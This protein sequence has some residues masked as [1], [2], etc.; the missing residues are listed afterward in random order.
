MESVIVIT[1]IA[2]AF[3]IYS[4]IDVKIKVTKGKGSWLKP[5]TWVKI[6]ISKE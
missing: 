1:T 6:K 3:I 2:I 5:L 4:F